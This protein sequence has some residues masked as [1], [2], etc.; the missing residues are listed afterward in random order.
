MLQEGLWNTGSSS[1]G[2]SIL[3]LFPQFEEPIAIPSE[4]IKL[5]DE[6]SIDIR[7]AQILHA[8]SAMQEDEDASNVFQNPLN[9]S[10]EES[11]RFAVGSEL[12][13]AGFDSF[14]S[15]A[16]ELVSDVARRHLEGLGQGV[17]GILDAERRCDIDYGILAKVFKRQSVDTSDLLSY[18]NEELSE[19]KERVDAFESILRENLDIPQVKRPKV[20]HDSMEIESESSQEMPPSSPRV[21]RSR[22]SL[23]G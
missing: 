5:F 23:S 3:P 6:S 9:A 1:V 19:R 21:T 18:I 13:N 20:D 10:V 17:R 4:S 7:S 16:L 8:S 11:V 14:E 15:N 22:A 12:R 2:L